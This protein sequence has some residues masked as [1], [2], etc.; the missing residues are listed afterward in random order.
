MKFLITF[1][2]CFCLIFAACEDTT[3]EQE[4]QDDAPTGEADTQNGVDPGASDVVEESDAAVPVEDVET[5]EDDTEVETDVEPTEDDTEATEDDT[6]STGDP[7]PE[8]ADEED[9]GDPTGFQ[10]TQHRFNN[11]APG[12]NPGEDD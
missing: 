4:P 3:T 5:T 6:E 12:A 9:P 11:P 8:E 10:N 7:E 2:T 1:L